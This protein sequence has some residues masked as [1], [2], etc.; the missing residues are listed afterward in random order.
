M[1]GSLTRFLLAPSCSSA[2]LC[3]YLIRPTDGV[4]G[5]KLRAQVHQTAAAHS[6]SLEAAGPWPRTPQ[7]SWSFLNRLPVVSGQEAKSLVTAWQTSQQLP[8]SLT[9]QREKGQSP[10]DC[11][12]SMLGQNIQ[13]GPEGRWQRQVCDP[14]QEDNPV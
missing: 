14:E 3:T 2:V 5:S 12:V 7:S 6:R 9:G 11:P 4:P 1:A 10:H 8:T 13:A